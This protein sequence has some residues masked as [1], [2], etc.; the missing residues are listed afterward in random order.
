MLGG[1]RYGGKWGPYAGL[2]SSRKTLFD[3][4]DMMRRLVNRLWVAVI[5]LLGVVLFLAVQ[6][7][8]ARHGQVQMVCQ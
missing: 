7:T 4:Y 5:V 8:A 6:L 3:E 2:G 1:I